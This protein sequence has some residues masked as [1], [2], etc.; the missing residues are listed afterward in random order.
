MHAADGDGCK[1]EGEQI[2]NSSFTRAYITSGILSFSL[3]TFS[4]VLT[5]LPF[6]AGKLTSPGARS[7]SKYNTKTQRIGHRSTTD[8]PERIGRGTPKDL[9]SFTRNLVSHEFLVSGSLITEH[10]LIPVWRSIFDSYRRSPVLN[11]V[12]VRACTGIRIRTTERGPVHQ[13]ICHS[14]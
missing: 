2:W 6:V 3:L 12:G 9:H 8:P 7:L 13:V 14:N 4:V 11:N 1:I 10:F 5:H